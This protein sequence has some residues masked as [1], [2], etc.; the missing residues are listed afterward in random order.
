MGGSGSD[1]QGGSVGPDGAASAVLDA[2]LDAV[3]ASPLPDGSTPALAHPGRGSVAV[4]AVPDTTVLRGDT[5]QLPEVAVG[6]WEDGQLTA[7]GGL[8]FCPVGEDALLRLA[9]ETVR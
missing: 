4:G 3:L 5:G 8:R 7:G 1:G 9:G 6:V 2:V